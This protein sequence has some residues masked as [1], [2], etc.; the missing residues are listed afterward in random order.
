MNQLQRD[1][2]PGKGVLTL[3]DW[4][5]TVTKFPY[6]VAIVV[7]TKPNFGKRLAFGFNKL[8]EAQET[9]NALL[10]GTKKPADFKRRLTDPALAC[11]L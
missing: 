5:D 6:R 4:T 3:E 8:P 1:K 9:F 11:Y 7:Q 2:T 10:L